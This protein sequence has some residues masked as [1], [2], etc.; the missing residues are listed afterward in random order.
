MGCADLRAVAA[1]KAK[2]KNLDATSWAQAGEPRSLWTFASRLA[3]VFVITLEAT[4]DYVI[5][6][7]VGTA[8]VPASG[9][10]TLRDSRVATAAFQAYRV[11]SE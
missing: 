5:W 4:T 1:I 3:T 6:V 8:T 7:P 11:R 2:V 9:K 10:A